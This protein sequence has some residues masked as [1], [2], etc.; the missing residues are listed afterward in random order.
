MTIGYD[1]TSPSDDETWPSFSWD[2]PDRFN[3]ADACLDSPSDDPALRYVSE[4]GEAT[5]LTYGEIE[6]AVESTANALAEGGI[7]RGDVVGVLLPQCPELLV[8][9]LATLTLGGTVAPLSMLL[10]EDHL[11]YVLEDCG[12]AALIVDETR[13]SELSIRTP[14]R[15]FVVDPDS[16]PGHD[17]LGGLDDHAGSEREGGS[18][19]TMTPD[20]PAFL[21]YTSGTTGAPKGVVQGHRYLIGSLPG[22]QCW[23]HLFDEQE[24]AST[25]VW[26]PAEW[27]WAGALFNVVYPTLALGGTVVA[28]ARRS[29]F[30]PARAIR[31]ADRTGVTHAFMPPTALAKVRRTGGHETADLDALSVLTCGGEP[32]PTDLL[33]WAESALDV[34]INEAYGQ[35]EANA[36]VGNCQAAYPVESGS[37]GKPYP[38][39]EVLVV[40]EDGEPVPDGEIG[41]IA[42]DPS[43]PALFLGYHD[44]PTETDRAF[45]ENGLFDT[46]DL[47]VR[48]E[49]GYFH[50]RGRSDELIITSGYR[51]SPVEVE[52]ALVAHPDVSAAVV[53]GVPDEQRGERVA[54]AI[55][56]IDR[57]DG[58]TLHAELVSFVKDRLGAYKAPRKIR[59]VDSLPETRTG[60]A[61]R[62]A[63]FSE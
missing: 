8:S 38:G 51:V 15:T 20:D 62:C 22:Y 35:T 24:F 14:E 18:S 61:D 4:D 43:D 26:T 5:A 23:F 30:E 44:D 46:G 42:L 34:V 11:S 40:N 31:V 45:F 59:F 32:L 25:R 13:A 52:N 63:L 39:H 55:V 47:A 28:Q 7:G 58:D 29:G 10:G 48:D 50:H 56:P 41:T 54:A 17:G 9:H 60:K 53:T 36:L 57:A 33:D 19:I 3:V 2:L 27:A 16:A 37:M 12:A 49:D 6:S 21:L 1:L